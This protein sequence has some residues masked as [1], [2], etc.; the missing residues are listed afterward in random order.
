MFWC[1]SVAQTVCRWPLAAVVRIQPQ[2]SPSKTGGHG[3]MHCTE[4]FGFSLSLLLKYIECH[5]GG[6]INF[7]QAEDL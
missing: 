5:I 3:E 4:K 1:P 6:W 7:A 2:A